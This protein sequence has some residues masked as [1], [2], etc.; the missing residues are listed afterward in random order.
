MRIGLDVV[1]DMP[2]RVFVRGRGLDSEWRGRLNVTGVANR[3]LV[4][5]AL[6]VQRGWFDFLDRRFDLD[7][8]L[9]DFDGGAITAPFIRIEAGTRTRE[10][11]RAIVRIEGRPDDIQL[12]LDSVPSLPQDEVMAHILFDR[13]MSRMTPVQGLRLAAAINQLRGGGGIDLVGR[14]R[15]KIGL[16][17]LDVVGEDLDEGAVR[18][19]TYVRDDIYVEV[20]R[21][22][23][24]GTGR[25]RVEVE[26]TRNFHLETEVVESGGG[27]VGIKWRYDY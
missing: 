8:G 23:A 21:G 13:D 25:A 7:E 15:Q 6:E 9:I 3:P 22:L 11:D 5:G 20:E 12:A 26:V 16:D 27:G 4:V 19:G 1:V 18:A 2:G 10:L 24:E 17:V 14:L